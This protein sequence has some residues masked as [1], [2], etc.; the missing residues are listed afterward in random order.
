LTRIYLW[1]KLQN[2]YEAGSNQQNQSGV[3]SPARTGGYYGSLGGSV[4]ARFCARAAVV[5]GCL[6]KLASEH[7]G[8]AENAGRAL[9]Q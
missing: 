2:R 3:L 4:F 6:S 8:L 1:G 5:T 7:S 9:T